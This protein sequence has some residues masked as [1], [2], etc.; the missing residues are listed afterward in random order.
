[1][2]LGYTKKLMQALG[3]KNPTISVIAPLL[4][5]CA[6][7][8]CKPQNEDFDPHKKY[9]EDVR[10]FSNGRVDALPYF[11]GKDTQPIWG[12]ENMPPADALRIPDFRF[13]DQNGLS[14]GASELQGRIYLANFFFTTCNGICPRTM[15]RLRRVQAELS[16]LKDFT[17][18]SYSVTPEID[19]VEVLQEYAQKMSID[20]Q[21]WHL[22]TG[23]RKKIYDLARN[24][25]RADTTVRSRKGADDFLHSEQAF[26]VDRKRYL[27]GIYNVQGPQDLNKIIRDIRLL[28]GEL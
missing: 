15:P 10:S 21:N 11:V 19:T 6:G 16:E 3:R 12:E 18:I 20:D 4:L 14:F 22:L 26:L 27:R 25:F 23:E 28:S 13:E 1:M 17:L 9:G 2:Q 5:L 24:S 8:G 7:L